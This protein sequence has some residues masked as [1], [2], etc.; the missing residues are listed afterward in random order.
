MELKWNASKLES[1]LI[2]VILQSRHKYKQTEIKIKLSLKAKRKKNSS[3]NAEILK[4]LE[5]MSNSMEALHDLF[6]STDIMT[7][8]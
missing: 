3:R 8:I 1:L 4:G 2:L 5:D 6:L 7:S